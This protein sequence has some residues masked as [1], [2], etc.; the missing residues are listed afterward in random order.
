M[1]ISIKEAM[2]HAQ[3]ALPGYNVEVEVSMGSHYSGRQDDKIT[4]KIWAKNRNDENGDLHS[5]S[6]DIFSVALAHICAEISGVK[7]KPVEDVSIDDEEEGIVEAHP[8]SE[9]D[10]KNDIPF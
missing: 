9:T 8:E 4:W 6:G 1:K 7:A 2:R 3:E 5:S 10:A